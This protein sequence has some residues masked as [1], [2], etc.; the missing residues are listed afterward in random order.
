MGWLSA[1]LQLELPNAV[2]MSGA[3]SPAT[4][5]NASMQPVMMPGEAVFTVIESTD[6]QLGTPNASAAS[7]TECGTI[8]SISSVVRVTVGI[9]MIPSATPPE[10]A[11]KWPCGTTISE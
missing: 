2:K 9:I 7:R 10:N 3:V 11:E 1:T 8:S 5:A 4:R 6:L